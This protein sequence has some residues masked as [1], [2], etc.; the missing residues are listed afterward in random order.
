MQTNHSI[1]QIL[2]DLEKMQKALEEMEQHL[3]T[4][5]TKEQL[6][7]E[8]LPEFEK[9]QD[10]IVLYLLANCGFIEY[11]LNI[12]YSEITEEQRKSNGSRDL[13]T[14]SS[15]VRD[16]FKAIALEAIRQ[17]KTYWYTYTISHLEADDLNISTGDW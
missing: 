17:V 11:C 2:S 7:F 1:E 14:D 5:S 3:G 6:E 15:A 16:G 10:L 8:K 9:L 12:V 13:R 4:L